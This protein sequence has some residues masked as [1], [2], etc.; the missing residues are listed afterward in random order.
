MDNDQLKGGVVAR[1]E[2][3]NNRSVNIEKIWEQTPKIV[4]LNHYGGRIA[5]APDGKLIITSGERQ[6][7]TPAQS[8]FSNLGKIVRLNDDGSISDDNPWKD[9]GS[10]LTRYGP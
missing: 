8:M 5:F 1:A 7:F 10:P 4:G 6:K 2:L 9:K 3:I